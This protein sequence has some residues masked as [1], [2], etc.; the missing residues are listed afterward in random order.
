[1]S[2]LKCTSGLGAR[3][4]HAAPVSLSRGPALGTGFGRQPDGQHR[5][6]VQ[7]INPA[8][9]GDTLRV[10][11]EASIYRKQKKASTLDTPKNTITPTTVPM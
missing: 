1:M 4:V 6:G 5:A 8:S 9:P 7:L 3:H 11:F 2:H 10:H